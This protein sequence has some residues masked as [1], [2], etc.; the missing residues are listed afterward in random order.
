MAIE[1]EVKI[2]EIDVERLLATIEAM[3]ARCA[4]DWL[5]KT[6]IYDF[7]GR[8]LLARQGYVRIRNE[9]EEW[10]LTYKCVPAGERTDAKVREEVD[11]IVSDPQAAERILLG[12]GLRRHLYFEKKRRH[13]RCGDIV[14]DI[15]QLPGIPVY[16]EIEAPTSAAIYDTLHRLE[17]PAHKALSWGPRELLAHYHID[18]DK[19]QELRF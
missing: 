1:I 12:L 5:L 10:H 3:G 2:L 15:D 11:T 8:S 9:G 4:G 16:L 7:P 13:Y 18:I 14:F 17:I 6:S 19:I